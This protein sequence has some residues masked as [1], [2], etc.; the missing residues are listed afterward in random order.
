[1][2]AYPPRSSFVVC[3][4]WLKPPSS[5]WKKIQDE[6]ENEHPKYHF[7][8]FWLQFRKLMS[9]AFWTLWGWLAGAKLRTI[10]VFWNSVLNI[11]FD[12]MTAHTTQFIVRVFFTSTRW[13]FPVQFFSPIV[14]YNGSAVDPP[15]QSF[16][17]GRCPTVLLAAYPFIIPWAYDLLAISSQSLPSSLLM[18]NDAFSPTWKSLRRLDATRS[19]EQ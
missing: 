5:R 3:L 7:T 19:V 15:A 2:I 13:A 12:L 16:Q 14:S 6:G 18:T 17:G 8:F 1:M 10:G 11:F 9:S 4:Y